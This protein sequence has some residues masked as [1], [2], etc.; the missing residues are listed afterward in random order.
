MDWIHDSKPPRFGTVQRCEVW[1]GDGSVRHVR[2]I[3]NESLSLDQGTFVY[4][5]NRHPLANAICD[6]RDVQA[7]R[8]EA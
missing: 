7:W 4:T 5:D 1:M 6:L 2:Q 8:P 3:G